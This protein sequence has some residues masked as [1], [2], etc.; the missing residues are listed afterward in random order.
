LIYITSSDTNNPYID[1]LAGIDDSTFAGKQKAR[2][3]NLTGITDA[4]LGALSGYGLW[5]DNVY[6]TGKIVLP[7]AGMTNDGSDPTSVRIYAG[8]T[9]ANRATADFR[10]TQNGSLTAIG[11][12]ELGTATVLYTDIGTF[13]LAIKGSDI[14]ENY[15]SDDGSILY[16]NRVGYNGGT[17]KF[18]TTSIMDGKESALMDFIGSDSRLKT[19]VPTTQYYLSIQAPYTEL[20]VLE[21]PVYIN[22]DEDS[23]E[24]E[25]VLPV[26]GSCFPGDTVTFINNAKNNFRINGNGTIIGRPDLT[27]SDAEDTIIL[28]DFQSITLMLVSGGTYDNYWQIIATGE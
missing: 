15:S 23:T 16:L 14:W 24:T 13:A 28:T 6:L 4:I 17:T 26:F 22:T 7:D 20:T 2:L 21:Y 5:S 8:D 11:I 10:V 19:W 3:G 1:I 25:L 12:A 27:S 9:Y 18:R